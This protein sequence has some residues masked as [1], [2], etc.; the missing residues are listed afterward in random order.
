MEDLLIQ[1]D[2][3]IAI[4]SLH[5]DLGVEGA[6]KLK[7]ELEKYRNVCNSLILDLTHT[8]YL[9]STGLGVFLYHYRD[10]KHAVIVSSPENESLSLILN[11]IDI[12]SIVPVV[13]NRALAY[14]KL[15]E[16][17]ACD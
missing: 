4:F 7:D 5:G 17:A 12:D 15:E 16:M 6:F 2:N 14:R 13:A 9:S 8:K 11:H 3:V 10:F 1:V